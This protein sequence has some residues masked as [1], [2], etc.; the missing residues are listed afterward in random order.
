MTEPDLISKQL[1]HYRVV[2]QIAAGG[3]GVVYRARDERLDRDVAIKVL[4]HGVLADDQTRRRFRT[5]ALT[6]SKLNHP[7]IAV[8]HDF[9][10]QDNVDFLVMEL[11]TGG[12]LAERIA[13]GSLSEIQMA[14]IG[15]QIAQA[16]EEA[17]DQGVVHRDLKPQNVVLTTKDQAKVLD[18]GLAKWYRQ[19]DVQGATAAMT[20]PQA[21]LGTLPYM[22]PEQLRDETVDSR[23]D[24]YA[25]GTILYEMATGNRVFPEETSAA[26]TD[27]ILNKIPVTPRALNSKVS[28]ELERIILKCLDKDPEQR[29]QTAKELA[30]DL[31]RL[32]ATTATHVSTPRV[33]TGWPAWIKYAIGGVALGAA[34]LFILP[35]MQRGAKPPP[36]S[37]G[38]A[39][40]TAGAIVVLPFQNLG[41]PED[42]FFADGITE[43]ITSRLAEI[44]GL[45]VTSR[46][47][48]VRYA[49]TEKSLKEISEELGVESVLEGTIRTDRLPDG[50]GTVRV[51]PQLIR[52]SND[53]HLWTDRYTVDLI[54]GE[55]FRVQAE[56]AEHV[57]EALDVAL[58][59]SEREAIN[60]ELT[61][62][63][64]AY[65][66]YLLG[67]YHWNQ[68]TPPAILRATGYFEQAVE[69]DST[70]ALAYAGVADSYVLFPTY[71]IDTPPRAEALGRAEKAAR[72]G[73]ALDSTLAEPHASLATILQ[74]PHWDLEGSEREF[75][76]A[77]ALDPRYPV[78]YYW[79]AEL[80]MA[81]GRFDEALVNT[82]KAVDLDPD[83][84]IA[85]H[86]HGS[87]LR[88]VGRLDAA[89]AALL[90]SVELEPA[91]KFPHLNIGT[92]HVMQERYEEA[93]GEFILGGIP[94]EIA[95]V[96]FKKN[97][98]LIDM[99]TA[100]AELKELRKIIGPPRD[101]ATEAHVYG[102]IGAADLAFE[103]LEQAYEENH[104]YIMWLRV[105]PGFR[106]LSSDPRHAELLERVGL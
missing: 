53:S 64:E 62:S 54:P 38:G 21:I 33:R 1:G 73:I 57:A 70:F 79:Y 46:T 25:L 24:L 69:R 74:F 66:K 86:L 85:R 89:M 98:G 93:R 100:V 68:R 102:L 16:L 99:E 92:I 35:L 8:I 39:T 15:A 104:P 11:V 23:T 58:L 84:P 18:F 75:R 42:Q 97:S 95:E 106:N 94:P 4:P 49:G 3:M 90:K 56:I 22:A 41:T 67:R 63:Q 48:A 87:S 29:Y 78:S 55:I 34:V 6:L 17:H 12:N 103:A 7:N 9:N 2:E 82:A 91:F 13:S 26:L 36:D 88:L 72:K 59:G 10:T 101:A 81:Q 77:I 71:G 27:A 52:A 30:V 40:P 45:R 80:L 47:T 65:E 51:T 14:K 5:E 76:K 19:T 43:E 96:V 61:A 37:G 28:S 60:K 50:T 20:A 32:T 105:M 31:H 83:S 44:S